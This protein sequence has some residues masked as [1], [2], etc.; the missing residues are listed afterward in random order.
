[1]AVGSGKNGVRRRVDDKEAKGRMESKGKV[2]KVTR[3]GRGKER[4]SMKGSW[5]MKGGKAGKSLGAIEMREDGRG[6]RKRSR[7]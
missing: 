3:E 5:E 7:R 4:K 6:R 2:D 1:M